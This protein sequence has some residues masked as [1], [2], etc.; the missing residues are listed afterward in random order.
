[1]HKG[2]DG[3][4]DIAALC[5]NATARTPAEVNTFTVVFSA[6]EKGWL[7]LWTLQLF[8]AMQLQGLQQ[9]CAAT[10]Q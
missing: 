1:M 9:T 6:C 10:Q 5:G 2:L 3:M 8:E 4:K 7:T